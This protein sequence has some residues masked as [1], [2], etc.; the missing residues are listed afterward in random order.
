MPKKIDI[1]Y[2]ADDTD[3]KNPIALIECRSETDAHR[4]IEK[5]RISPYAKFWHIEAIRDPKF[6]N[7]TL[8]Q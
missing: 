2:K 5:L 6:V 1:C 3:M 4:I 7:S 8:A